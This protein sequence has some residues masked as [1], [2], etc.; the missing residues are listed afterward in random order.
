MTKIIIL[1]IGLLVS[2]GTLQA[3]PREQLQKLLA[4]DGA[5]SDHF[6][7]SVCI[8]GDYAIVGASGNDDDG[9]SSGSAYIFYNNAGI[10][11]Q[12]AKLT[13]DDGSGGDYFGN[14]VSIYGN[15]A[16]VGAYRENDNS[17][18]VYIFYNNAGTWE[19]LAKLTADDG[20]DGDYFGKSVSI[21]GDYIVVGAYG[22]DD[23]STN[24]GSAYIFYNNVGTW[25][26]QT[27]LTPADGDYDDYFGFSVSIS[28]DYV[29]IGAQ[30]D[31]D[32]DSNSG[33]AYIFYNNAGTWEQQTKLT[34]SD[35]YFGD[36]FGYSV[37]I[38]GDFA[39]VGAYLSNG[40]YYDSGSAYIFYNNNGTWT[41]QTKLTASDGISYGYFGAAVSISGNYVIVGAWGDDGNDVT[42]SGSSY[43]FYNNEG[44]WDQQLKLTADDGAVNDYFGF[45]VS[46]SG[47]NVIIGAYSNNDDGDDSGSA[48]IFGST[49]TTQPENQTNICPGDNLVFSVAGLNI[50]AYQWQVDEGAGFVNITNGGVYS[51]ANTATL[52]ITGVTLAM[53]NYQYRCYANSDIYTVSHEAILTIDTE[54]PLTPTLADVTAE[55]S[56]TATAPT[57][58]DNCAGTITGTTSTPF[59]ITTQGTTVVTWTFDDGN[60]NSIEANQNIVI[61]D[62]TDPVA[63]TLADVTA[64]CSATVTAPTTT[65]NCVG[66]ITGTTTTPFPIIAQGITVV[67]WTFNDGNGNSINVD[68]NVILTDNTVP[69]TPTLDDV[70][71]DCSETVTAPTTIDNCAGTI[72][73]TTSD[74]VEY[75]TEGTFVITWTFEDGNENSIN[76]NQNVIINDITNPTI[77]CID[78]QTKQLSQGETVYTVSG[79]EFDPTES[80]DNCDGF[81]ILNNFNVLSTLENAEFPIGLT[82]VIWTI[83]DVANNE[84]QCSFDVQI[85]AFVG[86]ETL[87]QNGISIFPNP[88]NGIINFDFI[89]NNIQQIAISDITGK[90]IIEK[91]NIQKNEMIDLSN[92]ESGIYIIKIQANNEIFITKIVKE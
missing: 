21:F 85:N 66:A 2:L 12:Q 57:T 78:N 27:K 75:T 55:C 61:D 8:F 6:S 88:T 79:T 72:T 1:V 28:G 92:F 71:G 29:L 31:D 5:E 36:F 49:I 74:P 4:G 24:S 37:S 90:I 44:I 56:A 54:L 14:S 52:N 89:N 62:V 17:G 51:N 68:Q 82:T 64:E 81:S 86:I 23:N 25:E 50:S 19:Q 3:H 83:T 91:N 34:A 42:D 84:T 47:D 67:T 30:Q 11:E 16:V 39:V 69:E 10:W 59:P 45:S 18:S 46:I 20:S 77:S 22:D 26:Q 35:G 76:V 48:Y 9:S 60:G 63:P 33:S 38:S 87:Q 15:Y 80:N 58:T 32:N 65:D 53:N 73:G 13:A 70:I 40:S 7:E 41:Q 43:I